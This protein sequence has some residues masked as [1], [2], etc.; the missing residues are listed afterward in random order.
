[1]YVLVEETSVYVL[2]ARLI[3]NYQ[4]LKSFDHIYTAK[5]K[6]KE[7]AE[8]IPYGTWHDTLTFEWEDAA[9][10]IHNYKVKRV[11]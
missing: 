7:Y 6:L 3:L 11:L 2:K 9:G 8:M 10:C 1:M 5:E 4:L